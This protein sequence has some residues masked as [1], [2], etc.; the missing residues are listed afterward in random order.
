MKP[1]TKSIQVTEDDRN[2]V[3]N[4]L[5]KEGFK[6]AHELD[7]PIGI[8]FDLYDQGLLL[9]KPD[10]EMNAGRFKT[11]RGVR[12]FKKPHEVLGWKIR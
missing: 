6:T 9:V 2:R 11:K 5:T 10:L 1:A 7:E 12:A 3:M 4:K 8:F